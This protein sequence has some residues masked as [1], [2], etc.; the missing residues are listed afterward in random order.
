[1]AENVVYHDG[2][3]EER[4]PG[5]RKVQGSIPGREQSNANIGSD[6]N[7]MSDTEDLSTE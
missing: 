2:P 5:S 1:M 7:L 4:A 3:V 6:V